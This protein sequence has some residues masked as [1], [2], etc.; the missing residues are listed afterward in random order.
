MTVR[1]ATIQE[2]L[3]VS[4]QSSGQGVQITAP[5]TGDMMQFKT[6]DLNPDIENILRA[7]KGFGRSFSGYVAPGKQTA[8]F[9]INA[10]AILAAAMNPVT[11]PAFDNLLQG[12]FGAAPISFAD[13]VQAS[14]TPTAASFAVSSAASLKVGMSLACNI[15]GAT[16]WQVRPISAIATNTLTFSPAFSAA[17]AAAAAV[18]GRIYPLGSLINLYTVVSYLR[19]TALAVSNVSRMGVDCYIDQL[20]MDFS[21]SI[22]DLNVSGP[23]TYVVEK[24]SPA[25][26]PPIYNGTFPT[27]P[28]LPNNFTSGFS[29]I[30]PYLAGEVYFDTTLVS[31]YSAKFKIDN[32]G[33]Q[34]PVAFGSVAADGVMY[35]Q[36][37]IMLD[38]VMDLNSATYSYLLDAELKNPHAIFFHAGQT[39]GQ[40]IAFSGSKMVLGLQDIEKN[41]VT[42]RLN[43]SNSMVFANSGADTELYVTVA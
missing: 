16:G 40:F 2:L 18:I 25:G 26:S 14:P 20:E 24:Q 15:G 9:S 33:K 22:I 41:D 31:I 34:L 43:A 23:A 11:A 37:K 38:F 3:S 12:A 39:Q 42:A 5:A 7:D 8:K 35:G 29:P 13:T 36:R 1:V 10:Y 30:T 6:C 21:Q 4:F 17:P 19:D 27:L 28:T 32:G